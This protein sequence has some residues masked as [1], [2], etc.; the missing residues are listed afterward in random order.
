VELNKRLS[1]DVYLAVLPVTL[2]DTSTVAIDGKGQIL[3]YAV[4][5]Q[6]LP[7]EKLMIRLLKENRL[8]R[9]MIEHVARSIASFHAK[10]ATSSEIDK[11]GSIETIRKN[12]DENFAQTKN[13]VGKS[14]TKSQYDAIR[15][16]T[17]DY[18]K[19]RTHLFN[20][21]VAERKI[22]DCHGDLHLEHICITVPIR[23]F[24]CIEFNDRFRYSDTAADIAFLAMDLD[25]H[26]RKDLSMALMDDYVRFSGDKGVLDVVN[27]YK[28]YRAYVR[29]KVTSFLLDSSEPA[30]QAETVRA[31]Q[32]YFALATSYVHE[33]TMTHK[34]PRESGVNLV[35][36]CGLMG[37]GKSTIAK[38]VAERNGWAL[39]SSDEVRKELARIPATQHEY[40]P[41]G[42]GIY[43]NDFTEKTYKR[44]NE[45]AERVLRRGK[46]V[47]VDASFG[48]KTERAAIYAIAKA[49]DAK[50]TCIELVCPEHEI[51][52]RLETRVDEQ[53]TISDGRWA[54]F[55]D[56]KANF[57]KV[58]DF[59][60]EEHIVVDTGKQKD[61]SIK[62]VMH[63]LETRQ[64]N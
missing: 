19:K 24:D 37:T 27:F 38:I 60:K 15:S 12:T 34:V 32:K 29:G 45:I 50:F 64:A 16:F 11:Y 47:V 26:N 43:G 48:K 33:E 63:A 53:R 6:R 7:T 61:E 10:A 55:P 41:W 5:M 18:L 4:K 22:K 9:E 57:D 28:V 35:I 1:P 23:I 13:Y 62:Q 40:V 39:I 58:D 14:I 20:R 44:M 52:S 30:P 54:I 51:R 31:A 49:T 21:R 46:S 2:D 42:K 17:D 3:D 8:T 59:A 36:T 56:Q 25:H